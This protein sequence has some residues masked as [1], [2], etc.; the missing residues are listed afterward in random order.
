MPEREFRDGWFEAA[1][2]QTKGS[3]KQYGPPWGFVIF[4]CPDLELQIAKRKITYICTYIYIKMGTPLQIMKILQEAT[5]WCPQ[6]PPGHA[7]LYKYRPPAPGGLRLQQPGEE[8]NRIVVGADSASSGR[9]ERAAASHAGPAKG[10]ADTWCAGRPARGGRGRGVA[11]R[12][13]RLTPG[14]TDRD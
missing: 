6:R 11:T 7:F 4:R 3:Q 9:S 12:R 8:R 13:G 10:S 14:P 1:K 2:P 5:K